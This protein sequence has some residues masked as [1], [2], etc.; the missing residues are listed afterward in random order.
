MFSE[1]LSSVSSESGVPFTVSSVVCCQ[2]ARALP[3]VPWTDNSCVQYM[4]KTGLFP[5]FPAL[6]SLS[7]PNRSAVYPT[8]CS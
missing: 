2:L 7:W 6:P 3:V 8:I 4:G 5:A 1:I